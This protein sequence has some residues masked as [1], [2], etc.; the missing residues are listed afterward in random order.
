MTPAGRLSAAAEVLDQVCASRTPA[1]EVLK[2]WGKAHRFA[3]SKDRRAIAERVFA[4]LRARARLAWRMGSETLS[5]DALNGEGG[6]AL[7]LA[8]LAELDG[9]SLDEIEALANG[10]GHALAPLSAEE[11]ERLAHP[12][13]AEPDWV[14]A[15]APTFVVEMLKARFGA[16]WADEASAL[17]GQRAPLDLRVNSL[18]G[19]VEAA[20]NLLKTDGIEP[21][22]TPFSAIGLRLPAELAPDVQ[23]LRAFDSGWVEV[24]DEASQIAA[25][26]AGAKPGSTVIDYC[27]GGGGKTLALGAAMRARVKGEGKLIACDVNPKRLDAMRPRLQRADVAAEVRRIGST[28]QGLED[29]VGRADLVFV[30]APCSGSGTW[31]RHPEGAWRITTEAVQRLSELQAAILARASRLVKPGGRLAYAT[32]SVLTLENEAVAE[33]FAAAHP[34]FKPIPIAVAAQTPALTDAARARLGELAQDRHMLQLTPNRSGTDG[35]FLALFE[36]TA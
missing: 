12:A 6:R 19:G 23:K 24:Q 26:L 16:A 11:R 25:A 1:D 10:E 33:A 2:A 4:V 5:G 17:I 8:S 20:I 28:G 31:R 21:T 22:P 9:L 30:D 13:P 34:E 27:A 15:G 32:C 14:R 3:G 7:V 35:F 36:R 18:R 29:M